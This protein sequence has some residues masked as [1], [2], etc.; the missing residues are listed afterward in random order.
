M[1]QKKLCAEEDIDHF[2]MIKS[3]YILILVS[4]G[5][6]MGFFFYFLIGM[7][8]SNQVGQPLWQLDATTP[9]FV[10]IILV[11]IFMV[12]WAGLYHA[13]RVEKNLC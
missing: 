6:G 13:K 12:S 8:L 5:V 1:S 4:S 2:R 11:V 7:E 10:G 9:P 3:I